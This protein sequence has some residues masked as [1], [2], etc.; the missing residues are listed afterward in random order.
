[1]KIEIAMI[2]ALCTAL[3]LFGADEPQRPPITG[4]SHIALVRLCDGLR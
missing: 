1:M 2:T 3:P 4:L